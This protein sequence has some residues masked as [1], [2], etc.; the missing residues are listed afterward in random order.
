[1]P[2]EL[3]DLDTAAVHLLR[4][5]LRNERVDA[6]PFVNLDSLAESLSSVRRRGYVVKVGSKLE[7]TALGMSLRPALIS[8]DA[9]NIADKRER[10]AQAAMT[11][12]AKTNALQLFVVLLE[13]VEASDSP[14]LDSDDVEVADKA[15][16]RNFAAYEKA[17][18]IIATV[19]GEQR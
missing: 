7:L 5:L 15:H 19:K 3:D 6:K 12:R 17:E 13:L 16:A 11:A 2:S 8:L 14:D 10:E 18:D 4:R 9:R 1:V